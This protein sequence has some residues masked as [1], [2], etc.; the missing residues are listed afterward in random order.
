MRLALC[1]CILL[2]CAKAP[3]ASESSGGEIVQRPAEAEAAAQPSGPE[4]GSEL[5]GPPAHTTTDSAPTADRAQ[6]ASDAPAPVEEAPEAPAEAPRPSMILAPARAG[7][8]RL[9]E[10]RA[11]MRSHQSEVTGCYEEGLA[12][13]RSLAGEVKVRFLIGPQGRLEDAE[14]YES[15]L[16]DES[17]ESCILAAMRTWRFPRPRPRGSSALLTYP[18]FL[19]TE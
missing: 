17:V 11:V 3:E 2:G 1:F 14:V 19:A 12:R 5:T 8:V 9:Q 18:Y 15:S 13:N 16:G 6:V 7:Q 4:T 10:V